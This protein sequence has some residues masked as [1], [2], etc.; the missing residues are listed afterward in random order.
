MHDAHRGHRLGYACVSSEDQ[1]TIRQLDGLSFDKVFT[2]KVSGAHANCPQ[3]S[4]LLS[5]ARQGKCSVA[6]HDGEMPKADPK[7]PG[8][9]FGQGT[10]VF[11]RS[12]AHDTVTRII[13]GATP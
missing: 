6:P 10:F 9:R 13:D 12:P 7:P 2:D 5:H 3:L 11:K 8:R 1:N 4:A